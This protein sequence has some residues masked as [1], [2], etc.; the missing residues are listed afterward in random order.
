MNVKNVVYDLLSM[1]VTK[2]HIANRL[3]IDTKTLNR[4]IDSAIY[5]S[6]DEVVS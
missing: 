1:G 4:I 3:E 2:S 6:Q 5:I